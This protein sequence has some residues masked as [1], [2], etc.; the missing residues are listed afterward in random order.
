[1]N[2]SEKANALPKRL[3][4]FKMKLIRELPSFP[5]NKSTKRDLEGK[6][7]PNVLIDYLSWRSRLIGTRPRTVFGAE[8]VAEQL[9]DK[10]LMAGAE[11]FL[12]AIR[13]GDDVS[14]HL[15]ESALKR[16]YTPYSRS[17]AGQRWDDKDRALNILGVHHFHI[18]LGLTSSGLTTRSSELILA[19]VRRDEFHVLGVFTHEVF[20]AGDECARL[21]EALYGSVD[22]ESELVSQRVDPGLGGAG[23]ANSGHAVA[24]RFEVAKIMMTLWQYERLL[25][26]EAGIGKLGFDPVRSR[27]Y[28]RFNHMDLEL[29]DDVSQKYGIVREG[30]N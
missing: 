22:R 5:N 11:V 3:K 14:S 15:S 26:G 23:I 28:W 27:P 4:D 25:E 24:I 6:S 29:V 21:I 17:N 19:L 9:A 16:G 18:G 1:M 12:Q 10:S 8:V 7:L 2:N 13:Q 30:L 20:E